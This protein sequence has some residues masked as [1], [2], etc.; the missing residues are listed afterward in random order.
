MLWYHP[1]DGD[2]AIPEGTINYH[3]KCHGNLENEA[4]AVNIFRLKT[5]ISLI[6]KQTTYSPKSQ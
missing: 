2:E 6:K 1:V 3:T 5:S 4:V